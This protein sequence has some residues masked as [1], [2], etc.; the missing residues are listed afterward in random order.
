M[1]HAFTC[2]G[3]LPSQYTKMTQF[4]GLGCVGEAYIKRGNFDFS[5]TILFSH[6]FHCFFAV[7]QQNGYRQLVNTAADRSMQAA[8]EEVKGLPHY[9]AQGEVSVHTR[10]IISKAV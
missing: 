10:S 3:V 9:S 7:Y 2:A 6:I 1:V 8:V 4:G 5:P